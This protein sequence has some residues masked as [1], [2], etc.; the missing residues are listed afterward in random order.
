VADVA[1]VL[2]SKATCF[3]ESSVLKTPKCR[4]YENTGRSILISS[5]AQFVFSRKIVTDLK[6]FSSGGTSSNV[7]VHIIGSTG[8]LT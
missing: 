3:S 1:I 8:V 7:P 4:F 5:S 2:A 6:V